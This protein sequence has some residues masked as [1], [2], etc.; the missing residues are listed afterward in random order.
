MILSAYYNQTNKVLTIT[1][2]IKEITKVKKK[3][4]LTLLYNQ[5][6]LIGINV[7]EEKKINPGLVDLKEI[8]NDILELFGKEEKEMPFV[9]G[10]IKTCK[11][12]PK[13]TKLKICNVNIG[14]KEEQIVCGASNCEAN[15]L[16]VV[17]KVGAI[18]PN[19]MAI[20]P[21]K[22]IDIE[23]NGML[24]SLKELGIEK[25]GAK[26]IHLYEIGEKTPGENFIKE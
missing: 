4:N 14:N 23:S 22:V 24:C 7:F 16:A 19:A 18:M 5:D 10:E 26:G 9:I 1:K 8:D 17:A 21:S 2:K 3:E 20:V 6:E 11:A 25:E 15:K 13:S 12:H